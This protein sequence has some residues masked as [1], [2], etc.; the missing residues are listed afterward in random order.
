MTP[1]YFDEESY[2][3]GGERYPLNLAKAV[4]GTGDYEVEIVSYGDVASTLRKP[5]TD[6]VS[7]R[8]LPAARRRAPERLSW[9]IISAVRDADLVHVHQIFTRA[10]EVA[11]LVAKLLGK[12]VCASDHGGASSR[13]GSSLGMLDLIDRITAYSQFGASLIQTTSRVEVVAGGVDD[14]Y[15]TP[16]SAPQVRDRVVFVGRLM[17][18][19]GIDR[20]LAALP[21]QVPLSVCGQPHRE[22][23]YAL[24]GSLAAHKQ[25]EFVTDASDEQLRELYRRAICVVLPSVYVDCYGH[26]SA[27][28]ELMGLSLLEGM[29]CGAPAICSRVG[30]MPEFVDHGKTGFVFDELAELTDYIQ[31]LASDAELVATIGDEGRARVQA[32]Y[33]LASTGA[34]IGAVYDELLGVRH[35]QS[36]RDH[37]PVSA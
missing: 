22:D 10:G 3:G 9:E 14:V 20:L 4:S 21:D 5:I 24:L 18:H 30:G 23:Y 36:A 28:P 27:W 32:R 12:P 15:F 34:S 1:L 13:L 11:V 2:L 8:V 16:A 17:P 25:V 33:G 26:A 19:K 35:H 6:R 31:R 29:A 7:L 37:Q